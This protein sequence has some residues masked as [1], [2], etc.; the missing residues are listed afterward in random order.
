MKNFLP[1]FKALL[2]DELLAIPG[3]RAG[4]MF[5]CPGYYTPG[6][7]SVCHYNDNL[8]VKLPTPVAA[9]LIADD[10]HASANGP[11][12]QRR[13]M[14]AN[15]VFLHVPDLDA[16]RQRLPLLRESIVYTSSAPPKTR[17]RKTPRRTKAK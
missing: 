2:D 1:E 4:L 14:G 6:G 16:L 12:G 15:W 3:V 7:L 9:Q 8:F 13:S 11:M 10:P 17:A 5:G